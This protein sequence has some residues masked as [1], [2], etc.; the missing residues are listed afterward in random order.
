M[1]NSPR[2]HNI[3]NSAADP[4]RLKNIDQEQFSDRIIFMSMFNDMDWTERNNEETCASNS[5][6]GKI[7]RTKISA[8][9]TGH[10]SVLEKK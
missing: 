9:F 2:T 10:L 5:E 8:R 3:A 4:E 1:E 6:K 7:V